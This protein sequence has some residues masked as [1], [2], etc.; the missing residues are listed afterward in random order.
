MM[1][2]RI[3]PL[4]LKN[5]LKLRADYAI[6]MMEQ[7]IIGLLFRRSDY[8]QDHSYICAPLGQRQGQGE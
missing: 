4:D 6:M 8:E 1:K 3:I 2:T 7:R 5:Y